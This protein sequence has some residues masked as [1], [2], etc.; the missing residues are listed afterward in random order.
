LPSVNNISVREELERLQ[1]EFER[2]S[3]D[4]EVTPATKILFQSMLVLVTLL[5]S[6]FM[7]KTTR[8]D[9]RNSSKPSSQTD[10]DESAQPSQ[11]SKSHG[12]PANRKTASVAQAAVR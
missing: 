10:K 11:G 4:G 5:V 2:L 6:V 8:K 7:E 1:S 12:K 9:S 3:A